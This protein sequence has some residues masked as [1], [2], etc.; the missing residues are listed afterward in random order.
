[1]ITDS[2]RRYRLQ[3]QIQCLL[4][5]SVYLAL[6][7]T[8]LTA[9]ARQAQTPSLEN[10]RRMVKKNEEAYSLIKM[11]HTIWLQGQPDEENEDH[12]AQSG[13]QT[14]TGGRKTGA[15]PYSHIHGTWAQ[16]GV[17]QHADTD[18]FY[19]EGEWA[20]GYLDVVDGEVLKRGSKPDLMAGG[21]AFMSEFDWSSVG[22]VLLGARLWTGRWSLGE[23]LTPEYSV[24]HETI[25]IVDGHDTYIVDITNPKHPSYFQRAW[26]DVKRGMPLRLESY[27][28][29]DGSK[30]PMLLATVES[31]RLLQLTNG[32]WFPIEG[33]RSIYLPGGPRPSHIVVDVNSVTIRREDIPDSLF[34]L[35]FPE[36][37]QVNNSIVGSTKRLDRVADEMLASLNGRNAGAQDANAPTANFV[38]DTKPDGEPARAELHESRDITAPL[39]SETTMSVSWIVIPAFL[40]TIL[41]AITMIIARVRSRLSVGDVKR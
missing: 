21:I 4:Y 38:S 16:D 33:V 29:P 41:L 19:A 36:G 28:V 25:D 26:I 14:N 11:R 20:K 31:I 1:M 8:E 3:R 15:R 18:R 9:A 7:M 6:A 37:A 24:V 30:Q 23:L 2:N 35:T 12:F 34:E 39:A 5:C 17:R 22:P 10:I 13:S 32:G 40:G 27:N